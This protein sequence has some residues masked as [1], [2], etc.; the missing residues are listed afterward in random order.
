MSKIEKIQKITP[1]TTQ[2]LVRFPKRSIANR[3][4]PFNK[5]STLPRGIYKD[6][7]GY[8]AYA[9]LDPATGKKI[10]R[11]GFESVQHAQDWIDAQRQI[12]KSKS[13]MVRVLAASDDAAAQA[14][15]AALEKAGVYQPHVLIQ[16]VEDYLNR[17]PSGSPTLF[18]DLCDQYLE[19]KK[20]IGLKPR[21]IAFIKGTLKPFRRILKDRLIHT[22]TPQEISAIANAPN[23]PPS[24]EPTEKSQSQHFSNS[25]LRRSSCTP[26]TCRRD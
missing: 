23:T 5:K 14:A 24:R 7:K 17:L 13:G 12:L 11:A 2:N 4:F 19:Q 20:T 26:A 1:E 21:S 22:L 9:G 6:S 10:Q 16:A 18:Q 15:I 25:R 8:T 3:E